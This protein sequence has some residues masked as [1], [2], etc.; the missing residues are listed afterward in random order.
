MIPGHDVLSL[1]AARGG[2]CTVIELKVAVARAFGPAPVFGNCHGDAFDF[3]Q[4]LAF[5]ESKGKIARTG[6]AVQL[7]NVPACSGH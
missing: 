3:E 7:G 2:R 5:L 4:L 6:D 1:I